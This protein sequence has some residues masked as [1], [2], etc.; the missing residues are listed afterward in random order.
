MIVVI[1]GQ[2][3]ALLL[4]LN[5]QEVSHFK[6][7]LYLYMKCITN[8]YDVVQVQYYVPFARANANPNIVSLRNVNM[9]SAR[10]ALTLLLQHVAIVHYVM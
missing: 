9:C 1:A 2:N 5:I 6:L 4:V 7:C 10:N 3:I 8:N